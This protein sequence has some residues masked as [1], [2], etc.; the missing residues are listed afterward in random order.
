MHE[1]ASH[2]A[3]NSE[4]FRFSYA[5]VPVGYV[6]STGN[7]LTGNRSPRPAII[8][9][10]TVRTNSGASAGTG[11]GKPRVALTNSGT[12]TR[13]NPCNDRSTAAWFIA[14]TSGPRLP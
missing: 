12:T 8:S 9:A 7:A 5:A 1:S 14:T 13:C 11:N 4:T 2:T 6:P 10:V 3:T